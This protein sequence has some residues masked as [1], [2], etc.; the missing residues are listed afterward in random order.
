MKVKNRPSGRGGRA[1]SRGPPGKRKNA[2]KTR[3]DL[4]KEK[5]QAKKVKKQQHTLNKSH[6]GKREIQQ[7]PVQPNDNS[8]VDSDELEE[9][10]VKLVPKE[11]PK[12]SEG[13]IKKKIKTDEE[14]DSNDFRK[15]KNKLEADM[16]KQRVQQLL[17]ANKEEDRNIRMLEKL[18]KM[19]KRK[20]KKLPKSFV[21]EGLDYLLE[22]CDDE[23]MSSMQKDPTLLESSD[24]EFENDL[25]EVTGKKRQKPIVDVEGENSEE[26]G[27]EEE[28]DEEEDLLGEEEGS[29]LGDEDEESILGDESEESEVENLEEEFKEEDVVQLSE[30]KKDKNKKRVKFEDDV[31]EENEIKKQKIE[32]EDF[33]EDDTWED[34]YGRTRDKKGNVVQATEGKYIPPALRATSTNSV[35]LARL[36]R[37]MQGL[38]NRVAESNMASVASQM[39]Q[40]I[41]ANS[42]GDAN[43]VL[44]QLLHALAPA[45]SIT[46]PR[47]V[48][49]HACLLA[50]L[51]AHIGAEIGAPFLQ[52]TVEKFDLAYVNHKEVEDK[53]L[54]NLLQM[55]CF[56]YCFKIFHCT[57]MFDILEMLSANFEEKDV[58]LILLILKTVGPSLRKDDPA[59][60]KNVI[61]NLQ[62]QAS[63]SKAENA[64]VA[65]ML[66]VLMAIKNNNM[67]K[68][69]DYD[70]DLVDRLKKL[71]RSLLRAGSSVS[72]LKISMK[73]LLNAQQQ[74]KWWV[75]GSAWQGAGPG[76]KSSASSSNSSQFSHK[77]LELARKQRMNTDLRR[78]IFCILMTAED[79]IDAFDKLLHLGVKGQQEREIPYVILDCCLQ[80][81]NFNPYYAHLSQKFCDY[82]RK[83][84]MSVQCSI[85]DKIKELN[86]LSKSVAR[87]LASFTSFLVLNGGL[88][89]AVLK[90]IEFS[91]L[92][93]THVRFVRQVLLSLLLAKKEQECIEAFTRVPTSAQLGLFREGMRLFLHRYILDSSQGSAESDLLKARVALAEKTLVNPD[94]KIKF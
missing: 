72:E 11:K 28:A 69:P 90:V 79:F 34:I 50:L 4:R 18:M 83:F 84:K 5:R 89:L 20:S 85:W 10:M 32:D 1:G 26:S 29:L 7:Q 93:K 30:G 78:N 17:D 73:D 80:E 63:S 54:N 59:A 40:I 55:L 16:Q 57:L 64:R 74:G 43:E 49:E 24:S 15:E 46:P 87:N 25:A 48:A 68:I 3:R 58:E 66:D 75:V 94:S 88:T 33:V 70:P 19:N 41:Q 91:D 21:D 44:G 53:T 67:S 6:K 12:K 22:V 36:K 71:L 76:E 9:P 60:L 14:K 42:R 81:Q 27:V 8:D 47:M 61:L 38:L 65:F 62:K 56:M 52:S 86:T 77:L 45:G 31:E 39:E 2:P 13:K 35:K 82:D 92:D 37:Q 51:H 23:K